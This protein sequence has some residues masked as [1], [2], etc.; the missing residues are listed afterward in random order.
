MSKEMY[1]NNVRWSELCSNTDR[2]ATSEKTT[3]FLLLPA[4]GSKNFPREEAIFHSILIEIHD[5]VENRRTDVALTKL[6]P[7]IFVV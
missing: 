5:A 4:A 3:F 1:G 6:A 7:S 2:I